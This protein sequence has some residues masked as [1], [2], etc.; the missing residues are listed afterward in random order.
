MS[1][2]NVI[3]ITTDSRKG[4]REYMEDEVS[5]VELNDGR[6]GIVI[7][8][9]HGGGLCSKYTCSEISNKMNKLKDGEWGL[10][11]IIEQVSNEWDKLCLQ[12]LKTTKY[13][14][15]PQEREILFASKELRQQYEQDGYHSGTTVVAALIDPHTK[16]GVMANL[17]DSRCIWK[18]FGR[19]K[20]RL[21]STKDHTPSENDLGPL[22]GEIIKERNDVPRINGDLAVGRV[23]GD[24]SQELMGSV[25][26]IPVV[27]KIK[28]NGNFRLVLASDG[29]WDVLKNS[30][31]MKYKNATN[32]VDAAMKAG[33]RDNVTAAV[34][35]IIYD[36][37]RNTNLIRIHSSTT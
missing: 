34:L 15:T 9:G 30:K 1:G 31:V 28:W 5:V 20:G 27:T 26:H 23:V 25:L 6:I 17:G 35:N 18:D 14:T 19:N 11:T 37:S 21:R 16:V 24:N 22:G 4:L 10:G 8:D 2:T 36:D 12:K 13:P 32:L 3:K 33:T 7:C 29:L